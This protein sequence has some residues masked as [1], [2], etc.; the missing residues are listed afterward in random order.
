MA[1]DVRASTSTTEMVEANGG[2]GWFIQAGYPAHREWAKS[3]IPAIGKDKITGTSAEASGHFFF[4]TAFYGAEGKTFEHAAASLI[5][6]GIY[7][8]LNF[9]TFLDN[10]PSFTTLHGLMKLVQSKPVSREIR[11]DVDNKRKYEIVED[12]KDMVAAQYGNELLP[13]GKGVINY[14]NLKIQA[15]NEGLILVDGVRPQFE[16]GSFFLGRASNTSPK[17]TSIAEAKTRKLLIH[18]LGQL[19]KLIETFGAAADASGIAKEIEYQESL[20]E[21]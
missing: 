3:I 17:L 21:K 5:D 12:L 13:L 11:I 1:L 6:D 15:P 2:K 16:D 9:L 14:R 19:Q 7:S 18:R 10:Q 20:E 4:P 8:S